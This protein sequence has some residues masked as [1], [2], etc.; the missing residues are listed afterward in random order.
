MIPKEQGRFCNSCQ[1]CVVDFT[2]WA[3]AQVYDYITK[4]KDQKICGRFQT[5]QLNRAINIPPQP[6]SLLYKY[7][8]GLGLT[9]LFTQIPNNVR[10]QVPYSYNI[11]INQFTGAHGGIQG[12]ITDRN[13]ESLDN[14][15]I[16]LRQGEKIIAQTL[17]NGIGEYKMSDITPGR[18]NMTISN[19]GYKTALIKDVL[20]S[21]DKFI[22][23]NMFLEIDSLNTKETLCTTYK[24]PLIDH[25][26]GGY[27]TGRLVTQDEMDKMP[28][29][30]TNAAI[31]TSNKSGVYP[32]DTSAQTIT[33]GLVASPSDTSFVIEGTKRRQNL[34]KRTWHWITG[35]RR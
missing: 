19:S 32:R 35:R 29:R 16:E 9:L 10:A 22:T 30:M 2:S 26:N 15:Y 1:K 28:I 31:Y 34:F 7:F 4:H 6:H 20:V 5:T 17:S 14:V 33:L 27:T 23:V 18:Y 25:D 13:H 11:P 21:P 24:V 12:K 3:D 8:I